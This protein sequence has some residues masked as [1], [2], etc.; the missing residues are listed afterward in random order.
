[1]LS[2]TCLKTGRFKSRQ[3]CLT[4]TRYLSPVNSPLTNIMTTFLQIASRVEAA[5][6]AYTSVRSIV[7]GE[8]WKEK[9][10]GELVSAHLHGVSITLHWK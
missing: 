4:S 8:E 9:L 5:V 7:N 3:A 10:M 6:K 2:H 1:M